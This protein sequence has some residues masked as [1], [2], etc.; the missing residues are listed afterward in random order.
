[1]QKNSEFIV[2]IVFDFGNIEEKIHYL[3]FLLY[4]HDCQNVQYILY[5][6]E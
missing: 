6:I 4:N 5:N 2:K 3:K 1:M